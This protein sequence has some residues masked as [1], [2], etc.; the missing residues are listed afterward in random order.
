MSSVTVRI[1][2]PLRPFTGGADQVY[3]QART[4]G[5]ALTALGS[6][7]SGV[8]ERVM[9]PGGK[10]RNFVNVY[11]GRDNVRSLNGLATPLAENDVISIVPA[12]AGGARK[13]K[14]RR[15]AELRANISQVTPGA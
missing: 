13:G 9:D 10:L 5:E 3:V 7:H 11:R 14:D 6:A 12:V 15:L 2:T 1:P 4:V 8:L